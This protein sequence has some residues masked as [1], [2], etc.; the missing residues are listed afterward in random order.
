MLTVD[1]TELRLEPGMKILD[2]GCGAGRHL[3]EAFRREGVRVVGIDLSRQDLEKSR[4]CLALMAAEPASKGGAWMVLEADV[5]R[6]P[7]T[8]GA[9]DAVICS[10][11]LEHIPDNVRAIAELLRVLKP[12][13]D[14]VVSVP[15][16][17]PE[18]ICWALSEPYH[19][20]PGGHIRI[21]KKKELME[22]LEGAGAAC[23]AV[24][25][26]HALHAPYWWLRCL[27]GHK[28][29]TALP[30]RLYK[31]FLE[32]DIMRRPFWTG[33]LDR[34]LNPLIAKSIVYYLKKE[35]LP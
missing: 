14:L 23:R 32:W 33:F 12:G 2:A 17:F 35:L 8:D 9:F 7:F 11:V 29:E 15:R 6:L 20:E 27:V 5:T 31:R 30:V 16:F 1:F 24:R 18:R 10:E 4:A 19:Q 21:Y 34:L 26:K 28:N 22:L 25:Y 3:C 13:R